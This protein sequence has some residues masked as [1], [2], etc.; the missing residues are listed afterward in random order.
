MKEHTTLQVEIKLKV[1]E[2]GALRIEFWNFR[3]LQMP[4]FKQVV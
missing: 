1:P 3:T 4:I 2:F